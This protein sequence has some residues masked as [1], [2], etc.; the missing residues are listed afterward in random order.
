MRRLAT[1]FAAIGLVGALFAPATLIGASRPIEYL[2]LGDSIAFGYSPLVSPYDTDA[3]VAYPDIV[4]AA[5]RDQLVNAACPGETSSHFIDLGGSDHGC[6]PWRTLLGAPLHADYST[7]QL[8]FV[9]A[10]LASH[11]KT[12][13]IT[14]DMGA[15]DGGALRDACMSEADP[16][17]CILAGMPA[18]LATLSANL[19]TIYGHIR[20]DG[21]YRH[22]LVGLTFYSANYADTA[23][24]WAIA[25]INQV[26]AE[27]TM[28]WG[29]IVADGFGAFAAASAAFGGDT[30]AAGL[31]IVVDESPLTCDDHPSVAGRELLGRTILSALR[32]D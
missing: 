3:F 29:G 8:D 2:A 1:M 7:S 15:N 14:L 24:T 13:L 16:M 30:C 9:D 18:V 10:F 26:F 25:Q 19:D 17:S 28:A 12:R 22:K 5:L 11:P 23:I 4:A 27:R 21:G 32:P 31:R 6:G 20:E